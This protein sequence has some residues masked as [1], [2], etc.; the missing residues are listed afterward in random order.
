MC[1]LSHLCCSYIDDAGEKMILMRGTKTPQLLSQCGVPWDKRF[2]FYDQIHTT[3]KETI[4]RLVHS[5]VFQLNHCGNLLNL[6]K[7][8]LLTVNCS[9]QAWTSSRISRLALPSRSART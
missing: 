9:F 7:N 6:S 3:G 5:V 4:N 8:L 2:T 1:V